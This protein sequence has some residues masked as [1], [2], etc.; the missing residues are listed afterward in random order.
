M[1]HVLGLDLFAASGAIYCVVPRAETI[2]LTSLR[3]ALFTL[4]TFGLALSGCGGGEPGSGN[5]GQG[6]GPFGSGPNAGG[7]PTGAAMAGAP[8][9]LPAATAGSGGASSSETNPNV[10]G[11]AGATTNPVNTAGA[12][13]ANSAG[14]GSGGTGGTTG[15]VGLPPPPVF[16]DCPAWP[17]ASGGEEDVDDTIQVSGTFDGN[18]RRFVGAGDLGSGNQDEGQPPIFELDNNA[19]LRNVILG[20]PAADG[21]HCNGT[22]TLENVWWEDVGEDAA[23]FLGESDDTRVTIDCGGARSADDK[24]MQHNG[25]GT[26]VIR[27]FIVEDFGKL[28]RSCGNCDESHERH[29]EITDLIARAPGDSLVGVNLNFGD[30]ARLNN[31]FLR[32]PTRSITACERYNGNE[33][34]DEPVLIGSGPDP[35]ACLYQTSSIVY[36]AAQ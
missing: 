3:L 26:V 19:V 17:A 7:A 35:E 11:I 6:P 5:N 2:T 20:F 13:G 29:V 25:G 8:S 12:G 15:A 36:I 31:I 18:L 28:Y 27:Q 24:V 9:S 1:A 33:G 22:C 16:A 30:T 34:G 10:S 21:I 23:T 14:G 4:S 32:D